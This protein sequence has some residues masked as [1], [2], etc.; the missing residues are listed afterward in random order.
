MHNDKFNKDLIEFFNEHFNQQEHLFVFCCGGYQKEQF[1][2]PKLKNVIILSKVNSAKQEEEETKFLLLV[3]QNA[4]KIILHGL[5]MPEIVRLLDKNS[6][7]LKKCSW[8]MWGGDLYH[9]K[10]RDK[11][12]KEDAFEEIRKRVISGFGEFITG[13]TGDYELAKKWYGVKGKLSKCFGYIDIKNYN[14]KNNNKLKQKFCILV[15]NSAAYTNNH[16]EVLQK[17]Q[18]HKGRISKI[19]CP[20]SYCDGSDYAQNLINE[21]KKIFGN[22]FFPILNYI[23]KSEYEKMILEEVD[24]AIF[25]HERQQA[26]TTVIT[27]FLMGKK[28][29][30]NEK[31]TIVKT[32]KE[33]DLDVFLTQYLDK[34][35][36]F[37]FSNLSINRNKKI[38]QKVFSKQELLN[39]WKKIFENI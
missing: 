38:A 23:E 31:S 12:L 16:I 25:N 14:H 1:P 5:F 9:Y 8:V 28:I 30:L 13:T 19:I 35:D 34:D 3:F 7:L 26:F 33:L 6:Y 21:G 29:Y 39:S 27:L 37:N 4:K 17:L 2:I 22:K 15:G 10:Y 18:T 32:C 36:F 11:N 20:L 24:I